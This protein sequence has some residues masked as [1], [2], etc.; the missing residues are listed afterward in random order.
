MA[1]RREKLTEERRETGP[2]D[3]AAR[4]RRR[5]VLLLDEI[6]TKASTGI[7]IEPG[8]RVRAGCEFGSLD[9]ELAG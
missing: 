5:R 8:S 1:L 4:S 7:T 9:R 3:R 6:R 2:D